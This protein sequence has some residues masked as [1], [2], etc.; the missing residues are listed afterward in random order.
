MDKP[1]NPSPEFLIIP[2][3]IYEDERIGP[4][5][6]V[7]VGMLHSFPKDPDGSYRVTVS[8]VA[9]RMKVS[10]KTA[11]RVLDTLVEFGYIRKIETKEGRNGGF[12]IQ[13]LPA[14]LSAYLAIIPALQNVSYSTN[15][16][17]SHKSAQT[18]N[19]IYIIRQT[20]KRRRR[21][22][23]AKIRPIPEDIPTR[24]LTLELWITKFGQ[25]PPPAYLT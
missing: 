1:A 16:L 15:A 13:L 22:V 21:P 23:S 2:R 6:S 7:F 25:I 10:Y 17:E 12:R 5:E 20:P 4:S 8:E 11:M 3:L 9:K 14:L 19:R 18:E 24:T